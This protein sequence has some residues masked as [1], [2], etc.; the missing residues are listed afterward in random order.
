MFIK[1]LTVGRAMYNLSS[2]VL[3]V[4]ISCSGVLSVDTVFEGGASGI[5]I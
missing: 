4:L 1:C 3:T 2:G 5:Q